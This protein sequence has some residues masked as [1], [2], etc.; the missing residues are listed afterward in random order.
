MSSLA[1]DSSDAL[2]L[3]SPRLRLREFGAHDLDDLVRMHRE[4]RVRSQLVDD[5][6]LDDSATAARFIAGM[7]AFYRQYE[8]RGIWC[9]ERAVAADAE[10]VAEA[11]AAHAEGD[12]G[13]DLLALVEAP[14]WQF[15]GWFSLVQVIDAPEQVEIGSRLMPQAWGGSLA[16]DGGEWL[17]H[18]AFADPARAEVFGYCDP[19]NRSAAQCLRVLGFTPTGRAPYNGHVAAQFRLARGDWA[20]WHALPRR[21]RLRRTRGAARRD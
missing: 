5:L 4:P 8:G 6:A 17:L 10:S 19:G 20:A 7:Q 12:I 3:A 9:A 2:W 18:R 14:I 15:C 11:R 13:D 16:L 21:E 1:S